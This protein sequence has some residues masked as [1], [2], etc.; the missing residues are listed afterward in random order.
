VIPT[1][2]AVSLIL[3][4][5]V[6]AFGALPLFVP[7]LWLRMGL[8]TG[9]LLVARRRLLMRHLRG[10][11]RFARLNLLARV[12]L[13]AGLSLLMRLNLLTGLLHLFTWLNLL[14]R[15]ELFAGLS[16]LLMRLNLLTGLLHLFMRLEALP[17]T[18]LRAGAT[19][20]LRLLMFTLRSL[21][22]PKLRRAAGGARGLATGAR[23]RMIVEPGTR[24]RKICRPCRRQNL[25]PPAVL[26]SMQLTHSL[27]MLAVLALLGGESGV[28]RIH[29]DTIMF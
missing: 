24:M 19:S 3:G 8:G 12:D 13:F 6:L 14:V 27:R 20:R 1:V 15:L 17:G 26:G 21:A 22:T 2:P 28:T 18:L 16:L 29:G 10:A 5:L 4:G 9:H 23:R 11:R 25:R 7:A